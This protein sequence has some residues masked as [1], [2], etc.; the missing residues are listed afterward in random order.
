[1]KTISVGVS[2]DDYEAFRGEAERRGDSIARL[3]RE[4]MA[5]YRAAR[6]DPRQPLR[7]VPVLIG[8]RQR[9]DLPSRAEIYEEVFLPRTDEATRADAEPRS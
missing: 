9:S 3:I 6:I 4:A 1:M 7:D 8:H 5:A 2:E